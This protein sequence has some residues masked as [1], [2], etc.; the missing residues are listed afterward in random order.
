MAMKKDY[1]NPTDLKYLH[2]LRDLWN[3]HHCCLDPPVLSI[4]E[5]AG[6]QQ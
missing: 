1:K 6:Q 3:P 2:K 4:L 5:A